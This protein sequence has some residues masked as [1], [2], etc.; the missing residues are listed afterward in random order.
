M[1]LSHQQHLALYTERRLRSIA[2]M[3]EVTSRNMECI[4]FTWIKVG[5]VPLRNNVL[6]YISYL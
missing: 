1:T 3:I 5:C 6:A 2:I 4:H